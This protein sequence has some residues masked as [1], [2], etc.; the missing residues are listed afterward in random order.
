MN[1]RQEAQARELLEPY[2]E[3]IIRL[4]GPDYTEHPDYQKLKYDVAVL[5]RVPYFALEDIRHVKAWRL[6]CE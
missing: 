2:R 3:D 5:G 1:E 6:V 4:M